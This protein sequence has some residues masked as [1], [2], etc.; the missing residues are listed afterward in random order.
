MLAIILKISCCTTEEHLSWWCCCNSAFGCRCH[1]SDTDTD[2]IMP[3]FDS[4]RSS[5]ELQ[6][7]WSQIACSY[8]ISWLSL[9]LAQKNSEWSSHHGYYH[10][11]NLWTRQMHCHPRPPL[12]SAAASLLHRCCHRPKENWHRRTDALSSWFRN[13]KTESFGEGCRF[14]HV[15]AASTP[16]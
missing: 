8:C 1:N 6:K 14:L 5:L 13:Q 2:T 9:P 10:R 3:L 11:I 4:L 12:D 7:L 16:E 15:C